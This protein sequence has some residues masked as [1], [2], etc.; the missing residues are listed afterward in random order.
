MAWRSIFTQVLVPFLA[1][2]LV[3]VFLATWDALSS[4]HELHLKETA[5][6]LE[7]RGHLLE[8]DFV[9]A[10]ANQDISKA[11]MLCKDLGKLAASRVTA[12]LPSGKVAGDSNE[13]PQKMD[14]H[15]D[16]PEIREA[17]QGRVGHAQRYSRTL[18]NDWFYVAVPVVQSGKTVGVIRISTSLASVDDALRDVFHR[19]VLGSAVVGLLAFLISFA[20]ARRISRP[21]KQMEQ[22][23][24]QFAQGNFETRLPLPDSVELAALAQAMNAMAGELRA[25][26][27][28]MDRQRN[29]LDA[30]LSSMTEGVL[31]VDDAEH[32]ISLN[33]AAAR[34]FGVSMENALGR[35][36]L[37][38]AR[39]PKLQDCVSRIL[40]QHEPFEEEVMFADARDRCLW[41]SATALRDEQGRE[42]GAL[43]VFNDITEIRR[44]EHAR[45]DFVANVSHEIRTPVTSIKGYAET[46][47]NE[48]PGDTDTERRFLEIIARQ[49]DRL[50]SLV[51]D[52]L[53][54]AG[55]E[56][57]EG[58]GEVGFEQ[59]VLRGV[60]DAAIAPCMPRASEKELAISVACDK[61]LT[62][63]VNAPLLE[64]AIINLLDNAIKYSENGAPVEI[65][66]AGDAAEVRITVRDRGTGIAP[67][68]LP[69]IFERF[70]RADLARS[71][72][73]GGTGLGLAIVK[74]IA[75]IHGGRVSVES[76][77]GKGSSFTFHL[78]I[79]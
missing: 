35:D 38:V 6:A 31:A 18:H 44:L 4:M 16:R 74:H 77:L 15:G 73:L 13:D 39:N 48:S 11:D 71:R 32:V 53:S 21:L 7:V 23:A 37:E 25:H 64:Q 17:L 76:T 57:S 66:A 47:L 75:V 49:A 27:Q 41:V 26:I 8:R 68:H 50:C 9:E 36:L 20:L 19:V 3:A 67:E 33:P 52:I 14:N 34:L 59:T 45:S 65:A 56:R 24:R 55:L 51:D 40:A 63:R 54:L 29:Q 22:G 12:I 42:M 43:L 60:L 72:K 5:A 70:Y 62:A 78:P 28:A 69:R 79:A 46:L 2:I 10:L 61:A 58:S 30:V 1:V